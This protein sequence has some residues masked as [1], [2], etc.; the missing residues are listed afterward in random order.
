MNETMK[1]YMTKLYF[2]IHKNE[3]IQNWELIRATGEFRK[4]QPLE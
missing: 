2:E 1:N 3:L 4:I